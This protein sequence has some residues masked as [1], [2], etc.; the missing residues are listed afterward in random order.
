MTLFHLRMHDL[1]DREFSLRRYC[2][3]SGREVCH[4]ARKLQREPVE[5]RPGFQRSLSNALNSMRSKSHDRKTPTMATL[6][7]NDSGYGSNSGSVRSSTEA[8]HESRPIS[9]NTALQQQDF[10]PN[11]V[12]L[13]YSNYAQVAIKRAGGAGFK[14]YEFEYWG[15]QYVWKRLVRKDG[16]NPGTSLHLVKAGSDRV[17]AYVVPSPLSPSELEQER[18]KGGWVH[19]CS[20]WIADETIVLG[21]KDVAE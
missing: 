13:E 3:D 4:T 6:A 9:A 18:V 14:R 12:K 11:T 21:Q 8:D 20:M 10:E 19:P 1:R 16:H 7:R 5:K 2:R 17:L 15:V